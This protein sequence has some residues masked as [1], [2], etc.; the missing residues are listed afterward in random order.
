MTTPVVCAWEGSQRVGRLH[1]GEL[2][3][4]LPDSEVDNYLSADT[5]QALIIHEKYR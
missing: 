1:C 5:A 4:H 2:L 3:L